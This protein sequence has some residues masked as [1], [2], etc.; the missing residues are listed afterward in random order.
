M[1]CYATFGIEDDQNELAGAIIF[2][3]CPNISAL[4]TVDWEYWLHALYGVQDADIR[5]TFW[6]HYFAYDVRYE[7]LFAYHIIQHIFKFFKAIEFLYLVLP[8]GV[9]KIDC[10]EEFAE[11][12]LPRD[13][14]NPN[15]TQ[16]LYRICNRSVTLK[17]KIR[18]AVEEDNDDLV[19]LIDMHSERLKDLY[20]E[21]YIAEILTTHKDSGRHIIVAEH[22]GCAV[23]VIILNETVIY[24]LLNQ[25]FE[26]TPFNGLRKRSEQDDVEI[27]QSSQP[28]LIQSATDIGDINLEDKSVKF[29][30]AS[31][32]DEEE[33]FI[34]V[35]DSDSDYSIVL[36]TS[37]LFAFDDEEEEPLREPPEMVM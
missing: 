9:T 16:S 28:D 8:P 33:Y 24:E 2:H 5:N 32:E 29:F 37:D 27:L 11:R 21:F 31:F 23:S 7:M 12:L 26:L 10:L 25:E 20:G 36:T 35:T 3:D 4:P 14:K 1:T 6:I 19:A 30:S 13:C 22:N 17:Y 18:R 15:N 34:D